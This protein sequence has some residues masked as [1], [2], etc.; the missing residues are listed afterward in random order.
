MTEVYR[1]P[2]GYKPYYGDCDKGQRT[3]DLWYPPDVLA[4]GSI[5]HV[6][7]LRS[8]SPTEADTPVEIAQK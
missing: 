3:I 2:V 5:M 8:R 7:H 6:D 4:V 1:S